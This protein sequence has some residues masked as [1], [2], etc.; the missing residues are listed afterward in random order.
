MHYVLKYLR[1]IYCFFIC[2]RWQHGAP[3]PVKDMTVDYVATGGYYTHA[4]APVYQ[5]TT[6]PL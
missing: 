6:V 2:Y 4:H 5:S 3:H 1:E